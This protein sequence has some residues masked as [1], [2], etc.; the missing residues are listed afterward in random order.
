MRFDDRLVTYSG[1]TVRELDIAYA[2][3]IHKSQGSEFGA[4]VLPVS[5]DTPRRLCYRNLIY[6]GVTRAKNLLVLAGSR[7]VLNAM[8]EN[9][10]KTLRYSCL[11]YLL[12]DES[13]I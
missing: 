9:D 11:V 7:A 2:I 3:T 1:E 10:R 5:A 12:R 4:V 13:I 6:T 8:V